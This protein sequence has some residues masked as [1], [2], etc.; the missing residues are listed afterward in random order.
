MN[1]ILFAIHSVRKDNEIS[2]MTLSC[3]HLEHDV[4]NRY[5]LNHILALAFAL[6]LA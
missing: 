6:S 4:V 2:L 1:P 3:P 5:V